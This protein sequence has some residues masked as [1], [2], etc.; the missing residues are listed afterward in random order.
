MSETAFRKFIEEE[1]KRRGGEGS[2]WK[3]LK[4]QMQERCVDIIEASYQTLGSGCDRGRGREKD[5]EF[6]FELFG[7]DFMVGDQLDLWLIEVN[8]NPAITHDCSKTL[9]LLIP[10]M[11]DNVLSLAVEPIM[12]PVRLPETPFS[13]RFTAILTRSLK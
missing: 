13:N 11:L 4:H 2:I 3:Q 9:N 1:H 6:Y 8:T 12:K 7:L 5:H 10:K